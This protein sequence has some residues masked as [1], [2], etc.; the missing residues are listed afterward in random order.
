MVRRPNHASPPRR[1]GFTL[2]E[3]LV[4]ISIIT[5]L[6]ALSVG[7]YFRARVIQEEATTTTT[8][9]NLQSA[10]DQ[11]WKAV[12]DKA[13][14]DFKDNA[15]VNNTFTNN[16]A[17]GDNRR[18]LVIWTKVQ[19]RYEFPQNFYEA[20]RWINPPTNTIPGWP[21]SIGLQPK[22]VYEQAL[23]GVTPVC[24]QPPNPANTADPNPAAGNPLTDDDYHLQAAAMLYLALTQARGGMAA[25][26]P[27]DHLGPTA[28]ATRNIGGK[29]FK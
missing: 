15:N 19:L 10:L 25:F 16:V 1:A 8:V 11:Q 26:N 24:L 21:T 9:Q 5:V 28:V 6:L 4:V 18:A 2:I 13:R 14:A 20:A 7:A 12:L 23:N 17:G 3:L 29:D 27:T 22:S